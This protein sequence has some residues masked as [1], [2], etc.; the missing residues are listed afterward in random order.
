MLDWTLRVHLLELSGLLREPTSTG[1][2]ITLRNGQTWAKELRKWTMKS[3]DVLK[4]RIISM[5]PCLAV[6]MYV[7]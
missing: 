7:F 5:F 6:N 1:S 4:D 3:K 2:L